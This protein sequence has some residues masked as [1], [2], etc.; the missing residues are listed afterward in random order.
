MLVAAV[1][2]LVTLRLW[3]PAHSNR[4]D[5][6]VPINLQRRKVDLKT[7]H[8][9]LFVLHPP[10]RDCPDRRQAEEALGIFQVL[11]AAQYFC[12]FPFVC[13]RHHG[14]RDDCPR[15]IILRCL[16]DYIG[17]QELQI[18]G[19][20][21]IS[22]QENLR[23]IPEQRLRCCLDFFWHGG[24]RGLCRGF[25]HRLG[26]LLAAA[27]EENRKGKSTQGESQQ[28]ATVPEHRDEPAPLPRPSL[29]RRIET[30][31]VSP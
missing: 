26:R 12:P 4:Q 11:I 13:F 25:R 31:R 6:R 22:E 19:S 18:S 15:R 21:Q 3:I 23:F 24:F 29:N 17:G 1:Q 8:R 28:T 2:R 7:L 16:R 30:E 5:V 14:P 27:G 10:A 20:C 9:I